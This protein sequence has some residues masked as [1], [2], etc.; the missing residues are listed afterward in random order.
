MLGASMPTAIGKLTVVSK[1][2]KVNREQRKGLNQPS[3]G[4]LHDGN[5]V[6]RL[7]RCDLAGMRE[8]KEGWGFI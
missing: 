3:S 4:T 5:N 7:F 8:D 2:L 6:N 1:C